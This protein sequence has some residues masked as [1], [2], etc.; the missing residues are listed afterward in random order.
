MSLVLFRLVC[1]LICESMALYGWPVSQCQS[2]PLDVQLQSGIR[3]LDIRLAV[4]NDKLIAYHGAYPQKTSFQ[5]ILSIIHTFLTAPETSQETVVMSLKQ[6]DFAR[7]PPPHFSELVHSEIKLGA[8]GIDMW[9]LENRVP[10]LG[11]VRG[12]VIMFSRFG[13]DG[14]GW[15]N[16]LEGMGIHP[17]TWPDSR[18]EGF[19]W[20]CKDTVVR[21][22]DWYA[23]SHPLF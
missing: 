4:V 11:E 7:T 19:E 17:T 21:T 13:G 14:A 22:H 5:T 16:R 9:F 3:V 18:K 23:F 8:G 1:Y 20:T 6:E 2:A 12:K 15:D 10:R